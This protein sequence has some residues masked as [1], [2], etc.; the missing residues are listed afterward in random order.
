MSYL[1]RDS[2]LKPYLGVS[3]SSDDALLDNLLSA[4]Q[5]AIERYCDRA[6]EAA[7][8]SVRTFA[9]EQHS[10]GR[11]LHLDTDLCQVTSITN[12]DPMAT[13]IGGGA[14][15][16]LPRNEVPFTALELLE[17]ISP[18]W[19]G[20]IS[21]LGRWA[22]S[23]TPPADIK[24]AARAYISFMYHLHDAQGN[25][26]RRSSQVGM[27]EHVMQLLEPYRRLR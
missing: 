5:Q 4:A 11:V 23:I 15:I 26:A 19:E 12:G 3:G 10:A 21:I 9:A 24:Q 2:D 25:P 13:L 1:D 8:D 17:D 16:T 20:T 14:Y 6:F 27:P 22:Y 7:S 18:V